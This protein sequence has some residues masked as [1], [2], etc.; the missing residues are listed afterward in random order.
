M[1]EATI[2]NYLGEALS[3]P[4]YLYKPEDDPAV[5]YVL[6][7]KTGG[8]KVNQIKDAT[9]AIQSYGDSLEHAAQLSQRVMEAMEQALEL[10]N[11]SEVTLNSE[12][13][14]TDTLKHRFRYQAVYDLV[15]Y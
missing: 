7:E 11:I 3:V 8:S 13:N 15:F 14:F 12:Y 9:L 6:I 1:I 2:R 4:V 10:P 5:N